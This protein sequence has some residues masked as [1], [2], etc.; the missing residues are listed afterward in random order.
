M[1]FN[2]IQIYIAVGFEVGQQKRRTLVNIDSVLTGQAI[3][4]INQKLSK[5]LGFELLS[6]HGVKNMFKV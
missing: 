3:R 6:I 5:C 1:S 4:S 2:I